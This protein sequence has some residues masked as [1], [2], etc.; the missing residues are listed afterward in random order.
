M[1]VDREAYSSDPVCREQDGDFLL[2]IVE[3]I[4]SCSAEQI[5]LAPE[6]CMM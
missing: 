3:F 4:N 6:K 1:L 5:R 2:S